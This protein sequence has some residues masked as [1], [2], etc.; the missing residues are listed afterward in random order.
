MLLLAQYSSTCWPSVHLDLSLRLLVHQFFFFSESLQVLWD[1]TNISVFKL[2]L[3]LIFIH[4][5]LLMLL[6]SL[7]SLPNLSH[8]LLNIVLWVLLWHNLHLCL[9]GSRYLSCLWSR[10]EPWLDILELFHFER[11]FLI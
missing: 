8:I 6:E 3:P 11:N 10:T 9:I 7:L 4:L 2:M 1:L 5:T